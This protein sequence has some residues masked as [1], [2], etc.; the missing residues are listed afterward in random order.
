MIWFQ[1]PQFLR[2]SEEPQE[3]WQWGEVVN[4]RW[5]LEDQ[6]MMFQVSSEYSTTARGPWNER[7]AYE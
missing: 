2:N 4:E 1:C 3:T 6:H 7:T 5:L